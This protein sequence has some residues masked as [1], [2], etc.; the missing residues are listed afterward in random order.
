MVLHLRVRQVEPLQF[1]PRLILELLAM[2]EDSR[3]EGVVVL[4]GR[5]R[6][7]LQ[8]LEGTISKFSGERASRGRIRRLAPLLQ[9]VQQIWQPR[10]VVQDELVLVVD[11][12]QRRGSHGAQGRYYQQE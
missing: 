9:D 6:E 4:A 2:R 1:L 7:T 12:G 10:L 8:Q 5:L 3:A 11:H